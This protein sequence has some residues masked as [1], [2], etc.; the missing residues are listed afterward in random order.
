MRKSGNWEFILNVFLKKFSR[1]FYF[2]LLVVV[3]TDIL[4]TIG[5]TIIPAYAANIVI[6]QEFNVVVVLA[7][8]AILSLLIYGI[9]VIG[10]YFQG[11]I[12]QMSF[13][14][15]FDYVPIF[16][17]K[18]FSW[19]QQNIDSIEGKM[20][21]DQA[22]ESIYNGANVGIEAVIDQTI[23][24]LRY[25]LQIISLLLLMGLLS[26]WPA[27]V[28]LSLNILGYLIQS[29][30]N[31]WYSNHKNEQN[32]ITSYQEYFSRTLMERENGKDIRIF[33]M[34]PLF[35]QYQKNLAKC[36]VSWEG[37][38]STVLAV[39][40]ILQQLFNLAGIMFTLLFLI[41]EKTLTIS[42]C[43]FFLTAIQIMNTNFENLRNA[44]TLTSKNLTFVPNFRKFMDAKLD[45]ATDNK[46]YMMGDFKQLTLNNVFLKLKNNNILKSINLSVNEGDNLIVVG[47]NGA[48][49]SS[50]IKVLS[51]L[52]DPTSGSAKLNGIELKSINTKS[53]QKHMT[54]QFQDDV[55]LHFTIAEN[56]SCT[57]LKNTN[58]QK[59]NEVLRKVHLLEFI[60]TLPNGIETYVGNELSSNGV[61]ISGGQK[62]RLLFARVLYKQADL[63]ILDEPTAALD[64]ISEK[65]FYQLIRS[66]LSTKTVI[67][68][69]HR[70]GSFVKKGKIVVMSQG[71]IIAIG[72]HDDLLLNCK[73]YRQMWQAQ[74]SL[75]TVGD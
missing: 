44:Y 32:R 30:G 47:E 68:V 10:L 19:S 60:N 66:E 52:Y 69:T 70:L 53:L 61:L 41:S 9:Q 40:N 55:L 12:A 71:E 49:K 64:P 74:R 39:V 59:V 43:I 50:L 46:Q 31:R 8:I 56:I 37:N 24:I 4:Y 73:L 3:V 13:D 14:F 62:Q 67:F 28:V 48:G 35:H 33:G 45:M 29:L 21:I 36:L 57:D 51:G 2:L 20:I 75:Y 6:Q 7:T 1:S 22:Y 11:K 5:I 72:T 63:N 18:I 23:L 58:Y 65:H 34:V 16:S 38:Y 15:R 27:I 17:K 25:S 42:N 54:I 26:I